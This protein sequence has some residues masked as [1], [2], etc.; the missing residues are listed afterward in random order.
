MTERMA[1]YMSLELDVFPGS[2]T[3]PPIRVSLTGHW[4]TSDPFPLDDV[5]SLA[6]RYPGL[7]YWLISEDTP[8]D[9]ESPLHI[10]LGDDRM[11]RVFPSAEI[12]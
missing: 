12:A 9:E 2:D 7:R 1:L 8:T 6:E 11:R 3:R 5:F 10:R 4:L